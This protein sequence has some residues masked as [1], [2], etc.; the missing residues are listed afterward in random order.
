MSMNEFFVNFVVTGSL[1]LLTGV[2]VGG[3]LFSNMS[4]EEKGG[5]LV[6]FLI[7]LLIG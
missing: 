7:G 2:V 1:S 3:I 4:P 5:L 6:S